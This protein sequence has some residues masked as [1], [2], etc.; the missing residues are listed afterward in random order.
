M[1]KVAWGEAAWGGGGVLDRGSPFD[2]SKM[3]K[4]IDVVCLCPYKMV[5]YIIIPF[6]HVTIV[7]NHLLCQ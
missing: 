4:T 3:K 2:M 1:G 6:S 5:M 7:L